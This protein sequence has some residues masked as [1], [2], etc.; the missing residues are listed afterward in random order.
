MYL[1][2]YAEANIISLGSV[3]HKEYRHYLFDIPKEDFDGLIQLVRKKGK[4][5]E[6][7]VHENIECEDFVIIRWTFLNPP[8]EFVG[9]SLFAFKEGKIAIEREYYKKME[10]P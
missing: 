6:Y 9:I 1:A 2:A 5:G 3:L 4:V 8:D 10:G 7:K